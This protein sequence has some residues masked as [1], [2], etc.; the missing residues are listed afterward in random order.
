M[1]F[2]CFLCFQLKAQTNVLL[3]MTVR[4]IKFAMREVARMHV[5]SKFVD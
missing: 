5:D 3:I 4:V 2:S 1:V